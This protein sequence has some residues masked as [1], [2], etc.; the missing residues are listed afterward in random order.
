MPAIVYD[1]A[2]VE[3]RGSY[4]QVLGTTKNT[5]DVVANSADKHLKLTSITADLIHQQLAQGNQVR[6]PKSL[7]SNEVLPGELQII[8]VTDSEIDAA[9]NNAAYKARQM[10]TYELGKISSFTLYR[11]NILHDELAADG[12]FITNKN[13]E[14]KYIEIIETGNVEL[15]SLLEKYL[16]ARDTIDQA[17]S[18]HD[19]LDSYLANLNSLTTV[20]DIKAAETAFLTAF[21][22]NA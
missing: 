18:V 7:Q 2:I 11:Y 12:Y 20:D 16:E 14:Q 21:Y 4:Y 19:R 9:R 1:L 8:S 6:I 22:Q 3:D 10:V 17:L 15:I 5:F 13:R